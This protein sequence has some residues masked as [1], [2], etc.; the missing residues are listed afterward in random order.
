MLQKRVK[1][2]QSTK[3]PFPFIVEPQ[4]ATSKGK[5][6]KSDD[7]SQ[8]ANQSKSSLKQTSSRIPRKKPYSRP[9]VASTA[10]DSRKSDSKKSTSKNPAGSSTLKPAV[11]KSGSTTNVPNDVSATS[12]KRVIRAVDLSKSSNKQIGPAP[13]SPLCDAIPPPADTRTNA[14]RASTVGILKRKRVD[15]KSMTHND[16]RSLASRQRVTTA[17][18]SSSASSTVRSTAATSMRSSKSVSNAKPTVMKIRRVMPPNPSIPS[19]PPASQSASKSSTSET[20]FHESL[21]ES[22]SSH[23]VTMNQE[24]ATEAREEVP[25]PPNEDMVLSSPITG[26]LDSPEV[27]SP[28]ANSRSPSPLQPLQSSSPQSLV[29]LI[30]PLSPISSSNALPVEYSNEYAL[31]TNGRRRTRLSN[32]A[33]IQPD[34]DALRNHSS[35][36]YNNARPSHRRRTSSAATSRVDDVFSGMSMTALKNIT[37]NNT[38][39]NQQYVAAS[40]ETEI[41]RKNGFRP[42]SPAVKIK[43][44]VQRQQEEKVKQREERAARRA[45]RQGKP[46]SDGEQER[47]S[48]IASPTPEP[49]DALI[50][51]PVKH[52]RGAGDDEDYET[53]LKPMDGGKRRVKWDKGLFTQVFLDDI[54]PGMK[55]VLKENITTKGCLTPGAKRLQLDTLG[56]VTEPENPLSDFTRENVVVKKFVYDDD[57]EAAPPPSAIPVPRNTRSRAK[58]GKG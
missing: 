26:R 16:S 56:N 27:F 12:G 57:V 58:K 33:P 29:F 9:L 18:L 4:Q 2:S 23:P 24:Q 35:T 5:T 17:T 15:S 30:D 3:L 34:T 46:D 22:N 14:N 45:R 31:T 1:I 10:K 6:E 8:S 21:P 49:S 42:E 13:N 7:L 43:T 44:I 48:E 37:A 39:R 52:T 28:T 54:V 40:L 47:D 38:A 11:V 25:L 19:Q 53:P 36:T 55:A 50:D 20:P 41:I 32:S 51:A